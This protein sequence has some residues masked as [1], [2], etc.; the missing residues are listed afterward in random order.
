MSND[1]V[2]VYK[3][4]KRSDVADTTKYIPQYQ[5]LGVSPSE[6]KSA[7]VPENTPVIKHPS[8]DNPR[9]RP[10]VNQPYAEV[11][12]P[13][14]PVGRGPTPNVGNNM[15]H[16]WSS[17]DGHIIDDIDEYPTDPNN[18]M[19]DNNEYLSTEAFQLTPD[20]VAPSFEDVNEDEVVP[21]LND[22]EAGSY[23]L[24]VKGVPIC[25]GPSS[26]IEDQVKALIFG[27]HELS[28]G[29]SIPEEDLIVLKKVNIKVGVFLE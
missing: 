27:E 3:N 22:L 23:L 25:S 14:F 19:V 10:P 15:E 29:V 20:H 13:V 24:L 2:K 21:I 4:P 8:P 12:E 5:V 9:I 17:V 6:Y 7:V 28:G 11:P 1:K 16:T 18:P 26:E